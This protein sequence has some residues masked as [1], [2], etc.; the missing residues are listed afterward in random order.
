MTGAP[1][2]L[3]PWKGRKVSCVVCGYSDGH[4]GCGRPQAFGA[5]PV[6]PSSFLALVFRTLPLIGAVG[7][8][9]IDKSQIRMGRE[10]EQIQ[11][12]VQEAGAAATVGG[13]SKPTAE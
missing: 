1:S 2:P 12:S 10:A 9:D 8:G 6:L 5:L 13:S 7:T 3:F 11:V 4:R